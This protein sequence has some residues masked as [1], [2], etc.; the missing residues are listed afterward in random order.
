MIQILH[1]VRTTS[2]CSNIKK[3]NTDAVSFESIAVDFVIF[4]IFCYFVMFL[5]N[6]VIPC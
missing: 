1:A 6:L 3:I 5:N 4:V 2:S